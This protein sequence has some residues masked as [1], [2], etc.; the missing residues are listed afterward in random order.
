MDIVISDV[1][2]GHASV[3]IVVADPARRDLLERV[4]PQHLIA[5][6]YAEKE[7]NPLWGSRCRKEI[8]ALYS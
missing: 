5:T 6:T 8:C 3:D 1:A 7:G 2:V 4:A